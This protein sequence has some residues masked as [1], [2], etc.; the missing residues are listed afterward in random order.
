MTASTAWRYSPDTAAKH[1]RENRHRHVRLAVPHTYAREVPANAKHHGQEQEHPKKLD[2]HRG[3]ADQTGNGI[4]GADNLCESWIVPPS[5]TP[6]VCASKPSR[7]Q[8]G[9]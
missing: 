7:M 9:G 6:V 4:A 2:D 1:D 3:I 8:S 5:I